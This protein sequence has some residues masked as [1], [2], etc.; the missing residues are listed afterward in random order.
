MEIQTAETLTTTPPK[1]NKTGG[2]FQIDFLKAWMIFL[3]LMDHSFTHAFLKPYLA[4]FWERIAIPVFMVLLGLNAYLSFSKK[5]V[6]KLSDLY[7]VSYFKKKIERFVLPYMLYYVLGGIIR[8]IFVLFEINV[9][10]VPS[11][12]NDAYM[13]LGY[14]PFYGPGMWFMPVLLGSILVLPIYYYLFIQKPGATLFLSYMIEF[15]FLAILNSYLRPENM[16]N[17]EYVGVQFFFTSILFLFSGIG[18]GMW[19]GRYPS[20]DSIQNGI[21]FVLWFCSTYYLLAYFKYGRSSAIPNFS[22]LRGDYHMLTFPWS[23]MI[24]LLVINIFPSS[25]RNKF[26]DIIRLISKSTYHIL[27]TQMLYFSFVYHFGLSI[28]TIFDSE[29]WNYLWYFPLNVCLT[30]TIGILWKRAE[31][32]FYARKNEK[33]FKPFYYSLL[34]IGALAYILWISAQIYVFFFRISM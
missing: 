2:F 19:I 32:W 7:T 27:L 23:A 33:N 6:T 34:I 10:P 11:Y 4:I 14:T 29:P 24:V 5:K 26:A 22:W 17:V 15:L 9:T 20:I 30:F 1:P 3:V 13:W 28:F 25:M 12:E 16:I 8:L 31:D 21:L 18:I